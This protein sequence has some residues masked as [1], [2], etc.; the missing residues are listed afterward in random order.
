MKSVFKIQLSFFSIEKKITGFSIA[1]GK[2]T[3]YCVMIN[4]LVKI[5]EGAIH[6]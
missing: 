2:G 5:T 3:G 1:G 6:L 4:K